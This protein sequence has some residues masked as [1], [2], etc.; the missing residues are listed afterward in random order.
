MRSPAILLAMSLMLFAASWLPGIP[1][2]TDLAPIAILS[3]LA[4]GLLMLR[5]WLRLPKPR[6]VVDGSNVM[7]WANQRPDLASVLAVVASLRGR[8]FAPVVWFDANAGHLIAGRYLN[9]KQLALRLGL[10]EDQVHVA[11]SGMPADPQILTMAI[12]GGL[13]IVTNDRYRDWVDQFPR[14]LA[15]GLL[16]QGRVSAGRVELMFPSANA[17]AVSPRRAAPAARPSTAPSPAAPLPRPRRPQI[18]GQADR[19][20]RPVPQPPAA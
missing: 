2:H 9:A 14:L 8:G 15:P 6:I 3:A 4:A 5:S 11:K 13:R 12:K 10:P 1:V 7:Y 18:V 19:R 17:D 16:V 20:P